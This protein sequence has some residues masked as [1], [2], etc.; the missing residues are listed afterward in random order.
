M[1]SHSVTPVVGVRVRRPLVV[2]PNGKKPPQ[3]ALRTLSALLVSKRSVEM[4]QCE[5]GVFVASSCEKLLN[6]VIDI[7][8]NRYCPYT[9]K[10][11]P[12]LI[13]G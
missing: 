7:H 11:R 2:I 8:K 13:K 12:K 3:S 4:Y 10:K 5:C 6:R 9:A 1:A